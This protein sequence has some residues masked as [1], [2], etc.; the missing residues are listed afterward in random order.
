MIR[1][2]LALMFTALV[3][4]PVQARSLGGE[5]V[6]VTAPAGSLEGRIHDGVD[7]F[8]GIPY[9]APPVGDLR[10]RP[11][12]P[13][14]AWTGT[15]AAADF[16]NDCPQVRFDGD[17]TPSTQAMSEDCL[18]LNLWRPAKAARKLP[19]MVYI[20]GGAFVAGSSAS[21]TTDGA[22][23]ARRGA[24]VVSFNYRLGRFGFFAHPALTAEA[25]GKPDANFAFLDMIA[26]LK[27]VQA[28]ATAFGGDPRNITIFGESAGGAAVDFLM[29]SPA[30]QGLFHKAIVM[31]GANREPYARLNA[32]RAARISGEKAGAA[33]AAKAGLTDPDPATL[34]ALSADVVQ[35]QLAMWDMQADRFN[36]PIIDGRTVLADPVE[37]FETGAVPLI[38]FMVGSTG[39]ELSEQ[40][41]APAMIEYLKSQNDAAAIAELVRAYGDPLPPA[42]V[43]H[44][45]FTEGARGFARIMHRH[46]A[47]AWLYVFDHVAEADQATRKGAAHASDLAYLFGN[48]PATAGPSDRA[49]A[50]LMGDYWVNFARH[51]RPNGAGLPDWP[52]LGSRDNLLLIR[53]GSATIEQRRDAARLDAVERAA[54]M[55][56]AREK[57]TP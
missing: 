18:F 38:P 5:P 4:Q 36:G 16:G 35:G 40:P 39:A 21:P 56:R 23:L 1:A 7:G 49:A 52:Q 8:A 47:P 41:Y 10:W 28:N 55:R 14:P 50:K 46:G 30:A 48:L 11:P 44:Y 19:V 15:R 54:A 33:F 20:H 6:T 3:S 9:A 51:G 17:A 2:A 22:N 24:V 26:A 32:D 53:N 12:A 31:S 27:W 43:D 57:S 45:F 37:R 42:L 34:R 13:A 29:A 25:G